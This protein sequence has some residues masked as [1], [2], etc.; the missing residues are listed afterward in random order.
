MAAAV[1]LLLTLLLQASQTVS[2]AEVHLNLAGRPLAEA[3]QEIQ[4]HGLALVFS[5]DLVRPDMTVKE[6]PKATRL[7]DIVKEILAPHGLTTRSG[8]NGVLIVVLKF[9]ESVDVASTAPANVGRPPIEVPAARVVAMAGGLENIFH[10]LQL[11]PG[12]T[13]TSDFGSRQSV[14]GGG[15]DENLIVMDHIELHN[16]Y[17]LFGFVSGINPETV[18]TFELHSGAFSA[19]YGDR[20]SSLLVIDTRDGATK[21]S[22][23]GLASVSITDTNVVVE[24]RLPD[25]QR[26]SWLVT[27]RRTYYDLIAGRL[28]TDVKKFP[29]FTD[30]QFKVVWNPTQRWRLTF[31]GLA[32]GESMDLSDTTDPASF[33]DQA[34]ARTTTTLFG[35]TVETNLGA[36]ALLRSTAS[37]SALKDRFDLTS[38]GCLPVFRPNLPVDPDLCAIPIALGHVARA[39]DTT[40][41]E[42]LVLP[43][44]QRHAIDL[45]VQAR[46]MRNS[47]SVAAQGD[48]F[49]ALALPGLGLL[50]I[51]RLPWH[52][53]NAP[54]TSSIDGN[55][56]SAWLEDRLQASARLSIVPGIRVDH[57]VFTH[58]TLV[59]PRFAFS[60]ALG[61]RTTLTGSTGVHYQSP[62]YD[63]AF[64]GGAAFDLNFTSPGSATLKS[65]RAVQAVVGV[66][67]ELNGAL[68]LRVEGYE[69]RLD[70]L[71]VGRLETDAER[72]VR[73]AEYVP[74]R[75]TP[76]FQSEIPVD[77]LITGVPVNAG[78]GRA[79]G[80]EV[81]VTR[82]PRSSDTRFS[83]WAS[84]TLSKADRE[85]YGL[86]YPFDYDR[87]HAA[88]VVGEFRVW[89]RVT[90]SAAVQAATGFPLTVPNGVR[91]ATLP[92]FR[93]AKPI[94]V[95]WV[96]RET[97][98]GPT[99]PV[100][101]VDYGP[102]SG[103]NSSRLPASSR[104][105]FR[106]TLHPRDANGH[107]TFYL[108]VINVLNHRNR[109]AVFS[110][111]SFNPAGPRPVV[112]N[113]Y[114]GGFPILPS[115]GLKYRF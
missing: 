18:Q 91:V 96:V 62:G 37:S 98:G 70:R 11:L 86:T 64:L 61:D 15:P 32:S 103:I 50:G 48:D 19:Q 99:Y 55:A 56:V 13:A 7:P 65:E 1:A 107:W 17:R 54:V 30:G 21:E 113:Q 22:V 80:V 14:R 16:P 74:D 3:L 85:T 66:E 95:P 87:R 24:G 5:T 26:G 35:I 94:V 84:Y 29:G 68:S 10:T 101:V 97:D 110:D 115:L 89:P 92:A 2:P 41:R 47:L 76:A 31:H 60:L 8:E 4:A 75:W 46:A 106:A 71:I 38:D 33:K 81:L 25:S 69:R 79:R 49:P 82:R 109:L 42:E 112:V 53:E 23:Q 90:A 43:A 44:G 67:R 93:G 63:K 105:D 58:E 51:G 108:D 40:I 114:A 9:S 36:R 102:L 83:G 27:A 88:S 34:T 28:V 111:L 12:V 6:Q 59:S 72:Q 78:S 73:L 45:G 39:N 57:L 77:P 100:Y 52:V 20:L 104:V